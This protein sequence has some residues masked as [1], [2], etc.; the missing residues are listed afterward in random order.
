M[1]KGRFYPA[2]FPRLWFG[3]FANES[4][5]GL[6]YMIQLDFELIDG[7]PRTSGIFLVSATEA[8]RAM[9]YV[10]YSG[11]FSLGLQDFGVRMR[12]QLKKGTPRHEVGIFMID[13]SGGVLICRWEPL[14]D[15]IDVSTI[16]FFMPQPNFTDKVTVPFA[17]MS[18]IA[19]QAVS[20]RLMP[21]RPL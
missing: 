7:N 5:V 8:N 4:Y 9:G 11:G 17:G 1:H 12:F 13:N 19:G 3:N 15:A 6:N 20:N 16:G 10:E 21:W 2:V 18:S 14:V